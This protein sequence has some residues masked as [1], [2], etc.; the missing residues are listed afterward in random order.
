MTR[1]RHA[2]RWPTRRGPILR[3]LALAATVVAG[4]LGGWVPARPTPSSVAAQEAGTVP[5]IWQHAIGYTDPVG[6]FDGPVAVAVAPDGTIVVADRDNRRVQRLAPDGAFLSAFGSAGDGDA[7]FADVRDVAVLRDGSVVVSDELAAEV[8]RFTADG[9]F[10]SRWRGGEDAPFIL[11]RGLAADPDGSLWLVDGARDRV[12]HLGARGELLGA[13]G[14]PGTGLGQLNGPVDVAVAG[15]TILVLEATRFQRFRRDGRWLDVWPDSPSPLDP[16][17]RAWSIAASA[18][19]DVYVT[20]RNAR[21]IRRFRADGYPLARFNERGQAGGQ[22]W[23]PSGV[24]VTADG[25][26][27]VADAGL[28]TLLR[29]PADGKRVLAALGGRGFGAGHLNRPL[30]V[31]AAPDGTW[32]VADAD[33]FR[34]QRLAGDGRPLASIGAFGEG[35][36]AFF[37]PDG[38]DVASDGTLVVGDSALRRVQRLSA[39]GEPLVLLPGWG[40][41]AFFVLADI[42]DAGDGTILVADKKEAAIRRIDADGIEVARF[43]VR[44]REPGTLGHPAGLARAGAAGEPGDWLVTDWWRHRVLRFGADGAFRAEWGA[45]GDGLGELRNPEGIAVAGE[46][47]LVADAG[48]QRIQ[49]FAPDGAPLGAVGGPGAGPG[50]YGPSGPAGLASADD[51]LVV[52]D[53]DNHRL[54]VYA[55]LPPPAWRCETWDNPWLAG[56]PAVVD[57]VDGRPETLGWPGVVEGGASG[58]ARCLGQ[59]PSADGWHVAVLE[60]PGGARLWVGDRL[61]IDAWTGLPVPARVLLRPEAAGYVVVEL[62]TASEPALVE[63]VPSA[64][65]A[66]IALPWAGAGG[67]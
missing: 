49:A 17:V 21:A 26:V 7:R 8:E 48:N 16:L 22:S 52:A 41:S 15:G 10:L 33:H 51:R 31:A 23:R 46:T 63:R 53:R 44:G 58:A 2:Q 50:R 54:Q 67:R 28:H 14:V 4:L 64:R 61:I 27:L 66:T 42:A 37:T 57:M 59:W 25:D 19:G 62:R 30:D 56:A 6:T 5:L 36:G 11:P 32:V 38:L 3:R 29:Y 65:A 18:S 39:A 20:D 35:L 12:V 1:R 43:G 34:L 45:E 9:R 24:A 13:L 40:P 47:V 60:A 55:A